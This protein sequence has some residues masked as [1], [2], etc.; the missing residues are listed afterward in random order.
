MF[1]RKY[2]EVFSYILIFSYLYF[3]L[4]EYLADF[5]ASYHLPKTRTFAAYDFSE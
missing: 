3:G 1:C 5:T 2:S 4:N